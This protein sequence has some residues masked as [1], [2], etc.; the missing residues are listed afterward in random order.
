MKNEM[1]SLLLDEFFLLYK[2]TCIYG[3]QASD[4]TLSVSVTSVSLNLPPFHLHS[5]A[6]I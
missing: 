1:P 2:V 6:K 4:W 3:K 5:E